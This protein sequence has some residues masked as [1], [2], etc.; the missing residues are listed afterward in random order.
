MG[1]QISLSSSIDGAPYLVH[2]TNFL[3][4]FSVKKISKTKKI[5]FVSCIGKFLAYKQLSLK[6]EHRQVIESSWLSVDLST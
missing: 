6:S 5:L 1:F 4:S 3:Q 2:P